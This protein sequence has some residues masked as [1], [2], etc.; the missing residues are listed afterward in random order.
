MG[1]NK[2]WLQN[3]IQRKGA[4]AQDPFFNQEFYQNVTCRYS[5]RIL[6]IFKNIQLRKC[7]SWELKKHFNL[8]SLESAS[9]K[10]CLTGKI[11]QANMTKYL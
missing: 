6:P 11:A 1:T 4:K 8:N 7:L 5:L 10:P 9:R 2:S 3:R